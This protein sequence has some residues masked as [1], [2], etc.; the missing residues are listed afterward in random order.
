[1]IK[2]LRLSFCCDTSGTITFF[3][4]EDKGNFAENEEDK[5][6]HRDLEKKYVKYGESMMETE[7]NIDTKGT[8]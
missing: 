7:T 3:G 5:Q 4:D 8:C 6:I 1:M 2:K